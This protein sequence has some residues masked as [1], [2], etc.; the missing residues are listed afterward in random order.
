[1][2]KGMLSP[3]S[4]GEG[5]GW[6]KSQTSYSPSSFLLAYDVVL[7]AAQQLRRQ[8]WLALLES[9]PEI[10]IRGVYS[11]ITELNHAELGP[12][13][14]V[15]VD[16]PGEGEQV[17]E[18]LNR[19]SEARKMLFFVNR[20]SLEEIVPILHAGALGCLKYDATLQ[21]LTAAI[22]A[23]GTGQIALPAAVAASA[24]ARL[25]NP[26]SPIH[27]ETS[28]LSERESEVIGHLV[29]GQTNKEIARDL[30]LSVRTIEAHLRNIYGKL[31]VS[32]RTEAV[33]LAL[34]KRQTMP[35]ISTT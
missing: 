11:N 4:S 32:T 6:A 3:A 21:E 31:G 2:S 10:V 34:K 19:S 8:A 5:K 13:V 23:I 30:G 1:M 27:G 35:H 20:Y 33:L 15:L 17:A 22:V 9:V 26:R 16:A 24:L 29:K 14:I 7:L 18:E 12:E 25:A 28:L